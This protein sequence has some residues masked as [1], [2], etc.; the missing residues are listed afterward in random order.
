VGL[1][2]T[3]EQAAQEHVNAVTAQTRK[4]REYTALRWS[5]G[6]TLQELGDLGKALANAHELIGAA[7]KMVSGDRAKLG[8]INSR[9]ASA[10]DLVHA[11]ED[12]AAMS[13]HM[14]AWT[15]VNSSRDPAGASLHDGSWE[16]QYSAE[17]GE[18]PPLASPGPKREPDISPV[19]GELFR[20]VEIIRDYHP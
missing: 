16:A 14:R 9:E 7:V 18:W 6:E 19:I 1:C 20:I 11:S 15:R 4:V 2:A 17:R 10:S 8:A 13:A 5:L 3:R 12:S